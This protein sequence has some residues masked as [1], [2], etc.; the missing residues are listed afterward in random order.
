MQ[1]AYQ[2]Y[3]AQA[4]AVGK[5]GKPGKTH[6]YKAEDLYSKFPQVFEGK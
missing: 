2:R 3:K 1:A 4:D 5:P 6:Q